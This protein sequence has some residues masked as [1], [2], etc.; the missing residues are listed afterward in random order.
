MGFFDFLKNGK[1]AKTD[2][3]TKITNYTISEVETYLD[4][5]EAAQVFLNNIYNTISTD[6]ASF[7]VSDTTENKEKD[8]TIIIENFDI[9]TYALKISPNE[10]YTPI[11]FW[12]KVIKKMLMDG[13]CIVAPQWDFD[14]L[15]FFILDEWEWDKTGQFIIYN[16]TKYP[17]NSVLIFDDTRSNNKASLSN[18]LRMLGANINVQLQQLKNLSLKGFIK[19][20]TNIADRK[21][22]DDIKKRIDRMVETANI[23]GYGYLQQGEEIIKMDSKIDSIN[24]DNLSSTK[25]ALYNAYGISEKIFTG[26]YNEN[27]Y[28]AYYNSVVKVYQEILSQE[29]NKK[30]IGKKELMNG[31]KIKITSNIF[32]TS[33]LKDITDF[34]YKMKLKGIIS[35]NEAR[36]YLNLPSY[37]GGDIYETN[38]NAVQIQEDGTGVAYKDSSKQ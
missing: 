4:D 8:G 23:T 19:T 28:R 31:R 24:S 21:M 30:I 34:L 1:I 33:S 25:N 29:I 38:L 32:K 10:R 37:S 2:P 18:L 17:L 13:I 36:D 6:V 22:E 7:E 12:S 5:I 3:N 20:N 14:S 15:E 35:A 11:V 26:D 16:N 9:I 27:E